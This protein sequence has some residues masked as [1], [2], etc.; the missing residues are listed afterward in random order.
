MLVILVLAVLWAAVLLP[1]I[2]RSR[3]ASGHHGVSDFTDHLRSLGPSHAHRH[4]EIGGAPALRAGG[5]GAPRPGRAVACGLATCG[6]AAWSDRPAA[7]VPT[8]ARRRVT[9]AA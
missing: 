5:A 4:S 6:L 3:S 1:P 2:L 8:D 9:D 7:R